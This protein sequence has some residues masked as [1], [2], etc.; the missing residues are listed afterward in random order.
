MWASYRGQKGHDP[1][2]GDEAYR[3]R[4]EPLP[5]TVPGHPPRLVA[6]GDIHGDYHKAVRA[7][8]LAGLMDEHGRWAG[9]STVA[10]QVRQAA[11][12]SRALGDPPRSQYAH[13][14]GQGQTT[15]YRAQA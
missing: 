13:A 3:P 8:R 1:A 14:V 5:T 11:C 2:L 9:G 6:I 7:L 4:T 15:A 12:G 10:V